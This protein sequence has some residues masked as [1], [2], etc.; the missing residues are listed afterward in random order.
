MSMIFSIAIAAL[1]IGFLI[2][3]HEFGHFITAKM[4]KVT[5]L[6]F[7]I[8]FGP[9]IFGFTRGQTRY[10]LRW[11]P[12]GGYVKMLGDEPGSDESL[13][14]HSFL[15][16]KYW[17]KCLVIIAGS[18]TNILLALVLFI[19]VFKIGVAL[20][21]AKI[22]M[23]VY[24]SP[25]YYAGIE[26]GD[27]I[28]RLDGRGNVDFNDLFVRGRLAAPGERILMT[29]ERDGREMEIPVYAMPSEQGYSMIGVA[30][31]PTLEIGG[32]VDLSVFSENVSPG[33]SPAEKNHIAP[34]ESPSHKAGL[35]AGDIITAFNGKTV[36]SWHKLEELL[37]FNGLSPFS[38]TVA[39]GGDEKT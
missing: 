25:A 29:L 32:F 36:E 4:N 17:R 10:S 15:A 33:E 19:A 24:G 38:I 1:G 31:Y 18:A 34:I 35:E 9:E 30:P 2:L 12:L 20:P 14:E 6:N 37:S 11:V 13:N 21:S 28:I 7:S 3:A 26:M 27:V 22:G 23:V 5:V 16:Q 39:R 8:G